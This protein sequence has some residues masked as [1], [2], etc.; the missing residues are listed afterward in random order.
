MNNYKLGT[1]VVVDGDKKG[2]IVS[3]NL[4]G[5]HYGIEFDNRKCRIRYDRITIP[6]KPKT[7]VERLEEQ[8]EKLK[9]ALGSFVEYFAAIR[10][11]EYENNGRASR[12]RVYEQLM[13][14]ISR[15]LL[16]WEK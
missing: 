7:E 9:D 4:D 10:D 6:D 16:D 11:G 15:E 3:R 1:T 13:I 8:N 2:R 14:D 5:I 12:I